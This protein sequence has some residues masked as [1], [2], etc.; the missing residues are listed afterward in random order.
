MRWQYRHVNRSLAQPHHAPPTMSDSSAVSTPSSSDSAGGAPSAGDETAGT[1]SAETEEDG[2]HEAVVDRFVRFW[3]EMA[4][5]WGINRTMAQIHALLY[6]ADTPLNTDDVME[7]LQI[8]RG[9][10]STN[11]RAL[12]EWDLVEKTQRPDSRKDFYVA[13]TD[14]WHITAQIIEERQ[15]RELQ[16]V[17][18]QLE[19]C[20]DALTGEGEQSPGA[21]PDREQVLHERLSNLIRLMELFERFADVLLP[22]IRER[23]ADRIRQFM[24][25]ADALAPSA[26]DDEAESS[27]DP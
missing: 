23:N 6:A 16:P 21:L 27:S 17:R 8:S 22:L 4:S 7:R 13:E 15:R 9:N 11:L 25:V 18:E 24:A 19:A 3:G 1:T 5:S 12:V 26:S 20:T 14:V 2:R 10:A